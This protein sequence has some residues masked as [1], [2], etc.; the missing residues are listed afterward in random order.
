MK[1]KKLTLANKLS[2]IGLGLIII[3]LLGLILSVIP[4]A[5]VNEKSIL[6][7]WGGSSLML[8]GGLGNWYQQKSK[9]L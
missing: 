6:I 4:P 5:I 7:F 9:S 3:S 1:S 8:I 2:L